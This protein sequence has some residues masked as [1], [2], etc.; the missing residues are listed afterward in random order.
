MPGVRTEDLDYQ[1]PPGR[2]A[3]TPAEP[4]DAARLLVVHRGRPEDRQIEH[5]TVADLPSLGVLRRGDLMVVNTTRVLPAFF[6]ATRTA[7]GGAVTGLYLETDAAGRWIVLLESGGKLRV[8]EHLTLREPPGAE[9]PQHPWAGE[10][11]GLTLEAA[12]GRGRWCCRLEGAAAAWDVLERIGRPPLPPYIRK[13][14]AALNLPPLSDRDDERYN[15]VY[16]SEPGSVA[17]PTAGLHLTPR[18]LTGLESLGV[19]RAEVVLRVGLGTFEPIRVS[20]LSSHVM[21]RERVRI[22]A[23]TIEALRACRARGGR[24]FV[25]GTTTLRAL[26]SLPATLDEVIGDFAVETGLFIHPALEPPHVFRFADLVMT[27]FHL[28]RSTLIALIASLP[29]VGLPRLKELYTAAIDADYRFYSYGD[30][31]LLA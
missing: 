24:V 25:V 19:E 4:R 1:L 11:P 12:V 31:M 22:P 30:A 13:A 27:N 6:H 20:D 16:A 8:G 17:A 26:E 23:A 3:P 2:I 29:G 18:V 10:R 15:T 5:A 9:H 21:H 14:R 28:P 7:T